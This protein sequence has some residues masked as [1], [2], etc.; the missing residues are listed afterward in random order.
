MG[1][2]KGTYFIYRLVNGSSG[3][4]TDNSYLAML[5]RRACDEAVNPVDE[6][7]K[8]IIGAGEQCWEG[9]VPTQRE[10]LDLLNE[11]SWARFFQGELA[12][13]LLCEHVF[14]HLSLEEGKQAAA[15]IYRYLKPGGFIRLAVPDA[16]FPD[17]EYQRIVQV[18]GPGPKDH[19]AA[20]HKVVY[21]C[22]LLREVYQEAG[23]VVKLLEYHDEQGRFHIADWNVDE[24]PIYRSSKLD[25][26]NQDGVIK[27]ASLIIDAIKPIS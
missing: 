26:R 23:F 11:E 27:F 19:P 22:D 6:D 17:E 5:D 21:N 2:C 18:G 24:A 13:A 20:D 10:E 7:M 14:E 15:M 1:S 4:F 16:Y 25:H 3:I 9:W 12:D 8:V